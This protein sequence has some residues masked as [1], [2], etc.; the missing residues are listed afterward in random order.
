MTGS[1]ARRGQSSPDSTRWPRSEA[2]PLPRSWAGSPGRR[3]PEDICAAWP[4]QPPVT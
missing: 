2:W 4:R 1:S 3:K